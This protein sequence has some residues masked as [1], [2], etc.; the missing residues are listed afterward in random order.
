MS[1]PDPAGLRAI[2]LD[3]Q[4]AGLYDEAHR[5]T[6]LNQLSAELSDS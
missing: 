2:Y 6:S 1:A 4:D 3:R 5:I